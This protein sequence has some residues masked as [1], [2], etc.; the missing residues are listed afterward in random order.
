MQSIERRDL[1]GPLVGLFLCVSAADFAAISAK[2]KQMAVKAARHFWHFVRIDNVSK[3]AMQVGQRRIFPTIAKPFKILIVSVL[4]FKLSLHCILGWLQ[5]VNL[6]PLLRFTYF[7]CKILK[8][9]KIWYLGK[10]HTILIWKS[11]PLTALFE[12]EKVSISNFICV[13]FSLYLAKLVA[14]ENFEVKF[15]L[16]MAD[17]TIFAFGIF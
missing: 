16:R 1:T 4:K 14:S 11:V 5:L 6:L 13:Q 17:V 7:K 12:I 2:G 9:F 8:H 10:C 15:W 3:R